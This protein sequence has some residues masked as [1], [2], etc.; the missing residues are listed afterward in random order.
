MT[1]QRTS[2][3]LL[4]GLQTVVSPPDGRSIQTRASAIACYA[5]KMNV[6]VLA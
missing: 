1:R 2:D 3:N 6:E 4:C 5:M